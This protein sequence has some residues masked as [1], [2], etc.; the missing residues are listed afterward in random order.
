MYSMVTIVNSTKVVK[1]VDF[2]CSHHRGAWVV[3]LVKHCTLDFS[4]G[5]DLR[6]VGLSPE[7]G[8]SLKR[9]VC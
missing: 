5:H 1:R 7:S 8:S 4:S 2:K 3:Q 6:V 9:A